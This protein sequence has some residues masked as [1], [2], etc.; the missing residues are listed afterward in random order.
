[1]GKYINTTSKSEP[2]PHLGKA[3]KLIEDGATIVPPIW[4][5][6]LICVADNG[7]FECAAYCYSEEEFKAFNYPDGRLK[8]W[9]T[10][11]KAKELAK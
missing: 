8:Q 6:N 5:E 11:P 2:L 7:A 10:H 9:L 3:K 1:M 4:Q